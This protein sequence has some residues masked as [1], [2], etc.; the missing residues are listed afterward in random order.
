[1]HQFFIAQRFFYCLL[2]ICR[3]VPK[4]SLIECNWPNN[5]TIANN[6]KGNIHFEYYPYNLLISDL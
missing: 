2:I 5:A 4:L 3:T 1:M 6:K